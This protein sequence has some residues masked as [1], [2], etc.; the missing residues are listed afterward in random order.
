MLPYRPAAHGPLHDALV[1]PC[2][3]PYLPLGH[4]VQFAA[5]TREYFPTGHTVAFGAIEPAA[6]E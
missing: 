2:E 5:P 3:L 4:A 1:N 6:Q